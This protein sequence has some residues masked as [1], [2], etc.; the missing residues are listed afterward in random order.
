MYIEWVNK[1][2][3]C[4]VNNEEGHGGWEEKQTL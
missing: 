4:V 2:K 3:Y 1:L